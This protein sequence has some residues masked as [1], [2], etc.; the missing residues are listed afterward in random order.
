MTRGNF[1]KMALTIAV[2]GG[3]AA[4]APPAMA[5][6]F[7]GGP[8]E[9]VATVPEQEPQPGLIIY[10]DPHTGQIVNAPVGPPIQLPSS[11]RN[12]FDT[13]DRGLSIVR[14]RVRGGGILLH[15][16]GRFQSPLIGTVDDQGR[17]HLQHPPET[18]EPETPELGASR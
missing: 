1:S 9:D 15:L 16:R 2:V 14:S 12:A 10:V 8:S 17:V 11:L 7:E 18:P 5:E 6:D 4:S 3:L 13:S